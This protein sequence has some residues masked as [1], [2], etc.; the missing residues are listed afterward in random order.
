MDYVISALGMPFNG[1]TLDRQSLG[2]SETAA[3]YLARELA[4]RGHRV[5]VFTTHPEGGTWDGVAYVPAG[6]LTQAAPLGEQFEF[7]CRHTPHDVLIIQRHPLALHRQY[8]AKV[9]MHQHHDLALHRYGPMIAGGLWQADI[10]TGVSQWHCDQMKAIYGMPERILRVVPN[11]VDP[12]LYDASQRFFPHPAVQGLRVENDTFVML[13]QSRPERGLAHLVRPGGIMDRLRGTRA[14]LVYCGYDNT[15]APMAGFYAQLNAWADA[16]PNVTNLGALTKAELAQLQRSCDLLAYPTEFEEVSPLRG[17]AVID[18]PKGRETIENLWKQDRRDFWVWSWSHAE[19]QMV[20]AKA[21]KVIR[22]RQNADMV[23]IRMR[24]KAG[25]KAKCETTLTLTPDHE[26]MLRDGTYIRADQLKPGDSLMPF[27]RST[28]FGRFKKTNGETSKY[29]YVG[30]KNLGDRVAEHRY[31]AEMMLGR[32]LKGGEIVDHIDGDTGN[33]DPSNLQVWGSHAGH[34][35]DHWQ[36]L[37]QDEANARKAE[38]SACLH[39][40]H[41]SLSPEEMHDVKK[42][43]GLTRWKREGAGV[44][45]H[46]VVALERAENADAYC[47]EVER[48]HNFIANGI[49]VHNCITA[50]EAM[51]AGLPFLSSAHAALPETCK[52]SG[53]VLLP[54]KDGVADEDAFVAQ[55]SAWLADEAPLAALRVLQREATGERG[56]T[57]RHAADVLCHAV[58]E[59]MAKDRNDAAVLRHGLAH[60]DIGFA[61]WYAQQPTTEQRNIVTEYAEAELAKLYTFAEDPQLYKLHYADHQAR[62]YAKHGEQVLGEDVTGS[63]RFRGAASALSAV[64]KDAL[65]GARV[66]DYGCAHGHY[67]IPLAKAFPQVEFHGVDISEQAIGTALKWALR[68]QLTNVT[69][70]IGDETELVP[71]NR[72]LCPERVTEFEHM[73][74]SINADGTISVVP[75]MDVEL[76]TELFDAILAGE[77]LEHV[78]DYQGLLDRFRSMLKPGGV[79]VV[80]TPCGRWEHPGTAEFRKAREHL[81]HFERADI[82]EICAGHT[83]DLAYAPAGH[84]RAGGQLGSWIWCVR[85]GD[86]PL[87]S[88]D[89]HRKLRELRPRQ[90]VSACLIVKDGEGSLRRCVTSFI[91]WVDELVIGIDPATMDRTRDVLRELRKDYPLVAITV[92]DLAQP[93]LQTGFAAARNQTLDRAVGDWVLWLDADEEVQQPWNIWP[94]LRTAGVDAFSLPQ[95]HYSVNPQ[96]VLTTDHPCRL[97]RRSSGA[98]FYGV[99]HEHPEVEMGKAIP[100]T[101]MRSDVQFLHGGYV[102][103][104]TRRQRYRR[105]LPLLQRDAQENNGRGLVRFLLLRDVAQGIAFDQEWRGHATPVHAEQAQ[106]GIVLFEEMLES[107]ESLRMVIDA[108]Q[109]YSACVTASGQR[110]F[111]ADFTIKTVNPTA[112]D[113]SCS[114]QVSAKFCSTAHYKRLL[115]RISEEAIAKYDDKYL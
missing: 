105:N 48:T 29:W 41:A 30:R 85:F 71:T 16:L 59:V 51:H 87:G 102:D 12:A 10:V 42:R 60:S 99:V 95:V 36:R 101:V 19:E 114:T 89:Y 25:C 5:S 108:V 37:E 53:S 4:R 72:L 50:M 106:R 88:V 86:E 26:V 80:T 73:E 81:H 14:H 110:A 74:E 96:Q 18:M 34:C 31:V 35:S 45:N 103:E 64:L 62:Y 55:I 100:F 32:K 38:R 9:V 7:Y 68:E 49:A 115:Q 1:E 91:D 39:A 69:L 24:P 97:F 66:L 111:D 61:E 3:V 98:R 83:V 22:T 11:G 70:T 44:E 63:T 54:L 75:A 52:G 33:N 15:T 93:V 58:S 76:R 107:S 94:L 78:K 92:F 47:M 43:A 21:N 8:Q 13:Y 27:G 17:D 82:L 90:T 112:P 23:T 40:W 77:I 109:Y 84:D 56:R 46:V 104:E 2:G 28:G 6:N 113:L 65:P 79:L 20:L 67:L 57:W